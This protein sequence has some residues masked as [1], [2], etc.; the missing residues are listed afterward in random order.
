MAVVEVPE[1]SVNEDNR[2]PTEECQVRFSGETFIVET[3]S[4][5]AMIQCF[6]DEEFRSGIFPPYS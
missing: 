5:S 6:S 4:E 1:T 3:I 2:V